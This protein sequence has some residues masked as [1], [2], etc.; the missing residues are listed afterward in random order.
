MSRATVKSVT[1]EATVGK[2]LYFSFGSNMSKKRIGKNCPSNSD[3]A[4]F[5]ESARLDHHALQFCGPDWPSWNGAVATVT[6]TLDEC[7]VW[8]VLWKISQQHLANLDK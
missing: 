3:P 8:G 5:I 7:C 2:C 6:E 1:G 4:E